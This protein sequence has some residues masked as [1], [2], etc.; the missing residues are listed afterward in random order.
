VKGCHLS[1][2]IGVSKPDPYSD[3]IQEAINSMKNISLKRK[4]CWFL[5][6]STGKRVTLRIQE[7]GK[8]VTLGLEIATETGLSG[9]HFKKSMG[10]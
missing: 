3:T 7:T 5:L 1:C 6:R 10:N 8:S 2:E 4:R 9:H